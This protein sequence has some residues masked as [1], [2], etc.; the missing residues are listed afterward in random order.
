MHR[1]APHLQ[2]TP[3][4]RGAIGIL[5][6]LQHPSATPVP[7][8]TC[9]Q[10]QGSTDHHVIRAETNRASHSAWRSD[11]RISTGRSA[12]RLFERAQKQLLIA[13]ALQTKSQLKPPDRVFEPHR[14][15]PRTPRP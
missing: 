12:G 5:H 4:G 2:P 3:R 15:T 10:R 8:P 6:A 9:A 14:N 1:P 7:K 13:G 11:Q